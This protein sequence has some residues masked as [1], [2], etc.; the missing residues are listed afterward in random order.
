MKWVVFFLIL[1]VNWNHGWSD[2]ESYATILA[3]ALVLNMRWDP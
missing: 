3:M 2:W 1:A